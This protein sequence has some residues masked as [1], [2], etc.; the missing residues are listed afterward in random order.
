MTTAISTPSVTVASRSTASTTARLL[1]CGVA[2]APLLLG[3]TI[4]QAATRDGLPVDARGWH[5]HL[6]VG[7]GDLAPGAPRPLIPLRR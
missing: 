3:V 5:G 7:L 6:A 4:A 2:A 1:A